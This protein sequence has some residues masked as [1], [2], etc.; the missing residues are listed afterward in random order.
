MSE[1]QAPDRAEA[2][3]GW[4]AEQELSITEA[5]LRFAQVSILDAIS[6]TAPLREAL[7][8]KGGNALDF[9]WVPNRSTTDLDFT[10]SD[11][12]MIQFFSHERL[13]DL[14]QRALDRLESTR[15]FI[16]RVHSVRQFPPG[17]HRTFASLEVRIGF[18]LSTEPAL[19][20]RI[21]SGRPSTSIVRVEISLNDVVS[22]ALDV[23]V[24]NSNATI[25]VC[26]LEDVIAEKLR[27][28]LQQPIRNRYRK[29][30]VLDIAAVLLS[31]HPL[32]RQKVATYLL[33][34]A[35]SRA[36]IPTKSA[37]LAPDVRARARTDYD[38]L[39]STVR[40]QFIPFSEA[41]EL[42]MHLVQEL[43]LPE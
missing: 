13:R 21:R 16:G 2:V 11:E 12:S 22:E 10:A 1:W 35:S 23:A 20:T 40:K 19:V 43:G 33:E 6:Q 9:I 3:T 36:I 4:A 38:T 5:R 31:G 32:D 30:D 24:A 25:R 15:S 18:A 37:F 42:V 14:F 17:D 34:K 28:L 29:Q 41:W 8:L 27:S 7:V 39:Q 26:S